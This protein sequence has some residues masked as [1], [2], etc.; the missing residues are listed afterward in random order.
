[1]LF[2]KRVDALVMDKNVFMYHAYKRGYDFLHGK[3]K[4]LFYDLFPPT[5]YTLICKNKA[6]ISEFD[7]GIKK[8]RSSGDLRKIIDKN[9][10]NY[11][12]HQRP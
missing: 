10:K 5:H 2:L 11:R 6:L 12:Q 3:H 9:I 1:M 8:L 4:V 7:S